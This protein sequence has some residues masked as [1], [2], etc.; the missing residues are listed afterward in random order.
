MPRVYHIIINY[1]LVHTW[2][3]LNGL[4]VLSFLHEASD[5]VIAYFQSVFQ[6][7]YIISVYDH[8]W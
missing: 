1:N 4:V 3:D 8:I 6:Y 2:F 7:I 5:D